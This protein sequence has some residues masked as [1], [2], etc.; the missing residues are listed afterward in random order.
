MPSEQQ[1]RGSFAQG[2][3]LIAK[4]VQRESG[5]ELGIVHPPVLELPVLV[6]L[7]QVVVGVAGE[8]QGIEPQR[9]DRW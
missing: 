5:I 6:V 4:D 3:V 1:I 7:D 9:I 8:G 2:L